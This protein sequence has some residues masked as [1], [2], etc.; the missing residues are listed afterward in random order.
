MIPPVYQCGYSDQID[1]IDADG[2]VAVPDGPGL[3]VTLDWDYIDKHR[4]G[5]KVYE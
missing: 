4:S 5:L 1:C 2:M 3:G